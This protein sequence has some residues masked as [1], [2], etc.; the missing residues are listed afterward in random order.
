M[1]AC[2][3]LCG[4]QIEKLGDLRGAPAFNPAQVKDLIAYFPQVARPISRHFPRPGKRLR[5]A[6][7]SRIVAQ[8]LDDLALRLRQLGHHD[9]SLL[10][11]HANFMALDR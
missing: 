2:P 7:G 3:D 9:L 5:P 1:V 8:E 4:R 10:L 11:A 6:V